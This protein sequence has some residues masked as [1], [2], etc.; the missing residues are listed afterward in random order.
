MSDQTPMTPPED[1]AAN[2]RSSLSDGSAMSSTFVVKSETYEEQGRFYDWGFYETR[3]EAEEAAQRL[4]ENE[5]RNVGLNQARLVVIVQR[6]I[7]DRPI[8]P[9]LKV[10]QRSQLA[11]AVRQHGS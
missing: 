6:S 10:S 11:R 5:G 4:L 2:R 9:T 8:W 1:A 3:K 7:V